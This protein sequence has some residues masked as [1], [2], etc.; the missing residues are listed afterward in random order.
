MF[1]MLD[2]N[3]YEI[4]YLNNREKAEGAPQVLKEHGI[5]VMLVR[6]DAS[7]PEQAKSMA[8]LQTALHKVTRERDEAEIALKKVTSLL[9]NGSDREL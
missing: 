8:K 6:A 9:T 1:L 3:I 7:D 2:E 4:N 5:H